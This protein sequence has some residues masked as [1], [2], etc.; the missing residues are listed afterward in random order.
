MLSE[1][2]STHDY[3][4]NCHHPQLQKACEDELHLRSGKKGGGAQYRKS[5][6]TISCEW[7]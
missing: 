2:N 3:A 6:V 7:N 4:E 5:G 1:M